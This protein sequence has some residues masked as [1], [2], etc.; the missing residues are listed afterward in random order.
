MQ[1]GWCEGGCTMEVG[2]V[3]L[4]C[5]GMCNVHACVCM[6]DSVMLTVA[7]FCL[8]LSFPLTFNSTFLS[9]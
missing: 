4:D 9:R 2:V 3:E 7:F 6:D 1:G 5:V 8:I